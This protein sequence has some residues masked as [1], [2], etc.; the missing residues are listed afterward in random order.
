M[1]CQFGTTISQFETFLQI[2]PLLLC[3]LFMFSIPQID[4]PIR[5]AFLLVPGFSLVPFVAASE[6]L[7]MANRLTGRPVFEIGFFSQTDGPVLAGNGMQVVP[8]GPIESLSTYPNVFV[9]GGFEPRIV[10][11]KPLLTLLK[12]LAKYGSMVGAIGT[13]SFHLARAKL[14][15]GMRATVHWEYA[16]SFAEEFSKVDVTRS[17]Y[18]IASNRMT[19]SGGIAAMDMMTH[20]ISKQVSDALATAIADTFVHGRVRQPQALQQVLLPVVASRIPVVVNAAINLMQR[21]SDNR[22]S[23]ENLALEVGVS[24]RH[25]NRLFKQ[26]LNQTPLAFANG[27]RLERARSLIIHGDRELNEVANSVGFDTQSAF[28]R[29][30]RKKFGKPPSGS[31]HVLTDEPSQ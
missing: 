30:Y 15:D 27:L 12:D 21:Q 22:V 29:A 14:L 1:T 4:Q 26:Y 25:L 16:T 6:P 5:V 7:R 13:G 9:T 17:L 20:L 11:S 28:S 8:N 23:I 19:C 10:T 3:A 2:V 18:E 24:R 31:R